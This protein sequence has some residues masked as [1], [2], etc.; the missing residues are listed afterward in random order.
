MSCVVSPSSSC[1]RFR[2]ACSPVLAR[3]APA[4]QQETCSLH[5]HSVT[6][7]H[8]YGRVFSSTAPGLVMGVGT[9]G[10]R[11]LPYDECDTFIS[12][13]AGLTWRMADDGAKKYEWGDQGSVLLMVEDEEP[14]DVIQY[15]LDYGKTWCALHSRSS[16]TTA[17]VVVS[18]QLAGKSLTSASSCVPGS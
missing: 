10:D 7:P 5:L 16:S 15:S 17:D 13:D 3:A 6:T 12:T 11:L 2:T 4:T 8:N 18:P 1:S 14:T 9:V